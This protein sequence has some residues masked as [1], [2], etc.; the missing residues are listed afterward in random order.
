MKVP[1]CFCIGAAL[2]AVVLTATAQEEGTPSQAKKNTLPGKP[3]GN[4]PGRLEWLQ[5]AGFGMFIHYSLDSQLGS[6]ISHSMV[7]ASEDYLKRYYDLAKTFEP[8]MWNPDNVCALAKLCGMRYVVFTAKHHNGFCW[9]DTKTTD[10]NILNTPYRKDVLAEYVRACRKYGLAVGLY[11]S[12][13]DFRWQHQHGFAITRN[14]TEYD[15]EIHPAFTKFVE[16]QVRELMTRYGKIEVLFIDG[17]GKEITKR[18]TWTLQPECL[19]TR[20]AIETPEQTVPGIGLEGAWEANLTMGTQ[21]AYKPTHEEYKSGTR[22]IEILIETRAKGG[23]LL[24]NVGPKPNGELP[25]EQE[26]R[27]R[28]IALWHTV[29]SEGVHDTRPWIVTHE[30]N[31]WFTKKKNE[32]TVYC[33]VTK[34]P[35]W[36]RGSR[37]EF[38]L[39][40]IRATKDTRISV[41]GQND[42]VVEYNP[43]TDA[44]SRFNQKEDGL[45]VSVVRAQ[46]LYNNHKWPNPICI[47]IERVEPA[48]VPPR[49]RTMEGVR[50]NGETLFSGD[51]IA[52]G[53]APQV[54]AGFRY[55]VYAGFAENMESDVW[56][57]EIVTET[58]SKGAFSVTAPGLKP[59][60]YEIQAFVIHPSGLKMFGEK[61]QVKIES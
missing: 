44:R 45:H 42:K 32:S 7:G 29:N 13:E 43:D 12:P 57:G 50:R 60:T 34:I 33:F 10:F 53:D 36:P 54:K 23:S 9:W 25:I 41:L 35:D 1:A 61:I 48:L 4:Q 40:S 52:L 24:L 15:P 5:D 27:L 39:R 21:W 31:L 14:I 37:K 38:I 55:R 8:R 2:V 22:L 19:I 16:S 26:E 51:I 20:G 59:G 49:V 47:K 28:E 58:A 17:V 56:E 3:V 30:A 46:R 11:Y 6:V 18:T